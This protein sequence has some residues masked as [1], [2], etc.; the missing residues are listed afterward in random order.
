VNLISIYK[1][2]FIVV[3]FQHPR[4]KAS[5]QLGYGRISAI[6]THSNYTNHLFDTP[7][8]TVFKVREFSASKAAQRIV[9]FLK[10]RHE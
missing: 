2:R 9:E 4:K 3:D 1:K 8:D 6:E 7:L 5:R 10:P